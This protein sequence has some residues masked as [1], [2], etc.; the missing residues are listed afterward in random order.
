MNKENNNCV[1]RFGMKN[2]FSPYDGLVMNNL[3]A[4]D[5]INF[6][7]KIV[8]NYYFFKENAKAGM[9]ANQFSLAH[10][11]REIVHID[12]YVRSIKWNGV[13]T[14][15]F[16]VNYEFS[17]ITIN[18][19]VKNNSFTGFLVDV[20]SFIVCIEYN[21]FRPWLLWEEYFLLWE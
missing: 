11:K 4:S 14:P 20:N 19:R 17:P 3:Q 5:K 9:L 21:Y 8:P 12:H 7:I 1:R 16:R 18:Y 2:N 10:Q 13:E 6:F 15:T